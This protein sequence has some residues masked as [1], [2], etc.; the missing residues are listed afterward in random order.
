MSTESTLRLNFL[1]N[2]ASFLSSQ[3]SSTAA[4][5]IAVHNR[6]LHEDFKPLKPRQH[7]NFCGACGSPRKPEYTKIIKIRP[8]GKARASQLPSK[9]TGRSTQGGAIVYKCL[10]CHK[11][12]VQR[13]QQQNAKS[14]KP[15]STPMTPPVS[16]ST[17]TSEKSSS[18][19]VSETP[20]VPAVPKST[21]ENASSKKRAKARKQG[22]LQALLASK[23]RSQSANSSA[24][25]LDLFDF[26]QQ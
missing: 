7:E 16:T 4:H 5:L 22:G 20:A 21:A 26:L 19:P 8:K 11:R 23:Q 1:R 13:L 6:I 25:S 3:S 18:Q 14:Q 10:R 2:S 15:S 17:E 9:E 12:T 24:S